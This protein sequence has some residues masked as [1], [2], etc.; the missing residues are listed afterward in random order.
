MTATDFEIK[1]QGLENCDL[2]ILEGRI[3]GNTASKFEL[4]IR[5]TQDAGHYK[6]NFNIEQWTVSKVAHVTILTVH[7]HRAYGLMLTRGD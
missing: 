2:L 1:H 5:K 3:D 7:C 4:A 6:I